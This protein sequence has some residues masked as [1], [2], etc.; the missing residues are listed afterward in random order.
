MSATGATD[1]RDGGAYY[2]P[3]AEARAIVGSWAEEF[4]ACPAAGRHH[5]RVLRV[6]DPSGGGGAFPMALLHH[7]LVRP[8]SLE[9]L[10]LDP[11]ARALRLPGGM[12]RTVAPVTE[13]PVLTGFLVTDPQ[14]QPDLVVTN[15]PFGVPR[16]PDPCDRCGGSGKVEV[17]KRQ[18]KL[19]AEGYQVGQRAPCT[20]C[21]GKGELEYTR[22]LPVA[23][24][25]VERSLAV[26]RRY[27][28]LL[29]RLAMLEADDRVDLW[30]GTPL[31]HVDVLTTRPEFMA[32][33][34]ACAGTG[35]GAR[36]GCW[37]PPPCEQCL[38]TG[39]DGKAGGDATAYGAFLW[40]HQYTGKPTLG[41]LQVSR[42]SPEDCPYVDPRAQALYM[43][44]LVQLRG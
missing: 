36:P 42:W 18:R 10:D 5:G 38:G 20:R 28:L 12:L 35:L 44:H 4:R 33:C 25:H 27:V 8:G 39:R 29:L 13:D 7:N 6:L 15:P 31:R 21:K 3:V 41:W 43:Q 19:L 30:A 1:Y 37:L 11:E 9:V 16:P 22:A 34:L 24:E 2:T 26:S 23:R 40:D 17:D 14:Q 32:V